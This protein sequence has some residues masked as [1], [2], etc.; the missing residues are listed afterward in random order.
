MRCKNADYPPGKL[1]EI[2]VA[3]KSGITTREALEILRPCFRG[4]R[5]TSLIEAALLDRVQK[6]LRRDGYI[7]VPVTP[8][9]PNGE[10][11]YILESN[12][13]ADQL[14]WYIRS[15]R[16]A[17]K[18]KNKR[19]EKADERLREIE[20]IDNVLNSP[21]VHVSSFREDLE[22]RREELIAAQN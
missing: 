1:A 8:K 6:K 20:K 22:K 12:M 9:T 7:A 4:I 14:R 19:I 18:T 10:M 16:K 21:Q 2:E 13:N 17:V 3:A 5:R 11:V 15:E